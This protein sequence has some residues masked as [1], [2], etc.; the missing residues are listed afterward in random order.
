MSLNAATIKLSLW[1]SQHSAATLVIKS[2][3]PVALALA[4][5]LVAKMPASAHVITMPA[6]GSGTG[7]GGGC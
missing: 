7:G 6:C 3:L 1:T 4:I 2:V 5:A